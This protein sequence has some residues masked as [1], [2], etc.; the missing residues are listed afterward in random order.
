MGLRAPIY[1]KTFLLFRERISQA[2]QL[3]VPSQAI[4]LTQSA[5]MVTAAALVLER[6]FDCSQ[7]IAAIVAED[8]LRAAL[9]RKSE[10]Q[11]SAAADL[12]EQGIPRLF[13]LA[14]S[15]LRPLYRPG[16]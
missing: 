10:G 2:K 13:D 16:L 14:Y 4:R 6:R 15:S 12:R 3:Y 9:C 1:I 8:L 7:G 11:R 5:E